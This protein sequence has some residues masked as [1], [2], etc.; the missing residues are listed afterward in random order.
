MTAGMKP[1]CMYL[2]HW[3]K[4]EH[5]AGNPMLYQVTLIR[6][7]IEFD[8]QIRAPSRLEVLRIVTDT[9]RVQDAKDGHETKVVRIIEQESPQ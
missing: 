6:H 5:T 7:G 3:R 9:A 2:F 4:N 1:A 8:M